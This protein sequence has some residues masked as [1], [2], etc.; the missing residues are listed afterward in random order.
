MLEGFYSRFETAASN[1]A[2][3][4][5]IYRDTLR[6]ISSE[7][8]LGVGPGLYKWRFRPYQT[9]D[10][11]R[12]YANAHNDYLH[13][14]AE[15]GIPLALLF[16]CFVTWRLYR[17][18][19]AFL[20]EKDPGKAGLSLGCSAAILSI[21]LHSLTDSSLQVPLVLMVFCSV[22]AISWCQDEALPWRVPLMN[23]LWRVPLAILLILAGA[24][25]TQHLVVAESERTASSPEQLE[26]VLSWD[27]G[28]HGV[29]FQLGR[30]RRDRVAHQDLGRAFEYLQKAAELNP[31][32]WEYGLELARCLELL[33]RNLDARQEYLRIIELNPRS[34]VYHWR[35]AN[36]LLRTDDREHALRHLSRSISLDP[37]FRKPL[38]DL[39][40]RM[41]ASSR[42]VEQVWPRDQQSK[43]ILV[44]SLLREPRLPESEQW[45]DL[46]DRS[47]S[48]DQEGV[49]LP[50]LLSQARLLGSAP[51]WLEFLEQR[52]GRALRDR[53]PLT[54]SASIPFLEYLVE[55][56]RV[57]EAQEYW[58]L[59]TRKNALIDSSYQLGD[60]LV[61]N[62]DFELP[63]IEGGGFDWRI[64]PSSGNLISISPAPESS[65]YVLKLDFD[66]TENLDFRGLRQLVT[67]PGPGPYRL[68]Y[69]V[70]AEGLST[71]EGLYFQITDHSGERTLLRTR[72]I[73]KSIPWRTES[74]A[75]TVPP[76]VSSVWLLLRRNISR[77]IDNRFRGRL[78]LDAVRLRP[79]HTPFPEFRTASNSSRSPS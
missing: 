49:L 68:K 53:S 50:I 23:R 78:W 79:E 16:W 20:S 26:E 62:G 54:V 39:L 71:E 10:T 77:R 64:Y 14:A 41:G 4:I 19:K 47:W 8:I 33:N 61:W 7:P 21:L 11:E 55:M 75:F 42:E 13:S 1:G 48:Q 28:A 46:I 38:F 15:W 66:G 60:S 27:P 58:L 2:E 69:R 22:L 9:G 24:R 73:L 65:G 37:T 3:R 31:Y 72:Q 34:A 56:G 44:E 5:L 59:L 18:A 43:V 25:I 12:L 45:V 32:S 35:F 29:A 74:A 63:L 40:F 36:F 76:G 30:L 52:L 67:V 51:P 17:S 6:L 57:K 70:R